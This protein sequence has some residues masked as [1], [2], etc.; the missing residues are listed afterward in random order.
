[1]KKPKIAIGKTWGFHV[2]NQKTKL[3][4][5]C[6]K[7]GKYKFAD[8]SA[9]RKRKKRTKPEKAMMS[10]LQDLGLDYEE[11]FSLPFTNTWRVYDFW[12]KG[13]NLLIEVDGDYIHYNTET[14]NGSMNAM[15]IKNKQNDVIKTWLAKQRGYQIIRFWETTLENHKELVIERLNK[16]MENV[17]YKEA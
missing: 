6:L 12:I 15:H 9:G 11:E 8:P 4:K 1:M 13:T 2:V 14:Q 5:L 3:L 10:I 16:Q 17:I 7:S